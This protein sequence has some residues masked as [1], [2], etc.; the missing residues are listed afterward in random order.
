M[1]KSQMVTALRPNTLCSHSHKFLALW[2]NLALPRWRSPTTFRPSV[3]SRLLYP[4]CSL[5]SHGYFSITLIQCFSI[6]HEKLFHSITPI[7]SL[8]TVRHHSLPCSTG[9]LPMHLWGLRPF[10][11]F[12]FPH[13]KIFF[14]KILH[15]NL[16]RCQNVP[17]HL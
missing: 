8:Q 1:G 12:P 3:H 17:R 9:F 4:P 6:F 7:H 13:S 16:K 10:N 11:M 14:F 15:S 5:P 2:H